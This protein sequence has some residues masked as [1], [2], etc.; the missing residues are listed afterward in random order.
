[1]GDNMKIIKYFW[2]LV[3][4]AVP[5]V[6]AN[7]QNL[8]KLQTGEVGDYLVVRLTSLVDQIVINNV[9]INRG[10]CE[11]PSIGNPKKGTILKFG[12]SKDWRWMVHNSYNG[13][14]YPCEILEIT[15]NTNGGVLTY[16][17]Q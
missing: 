15:I 5:S 8:I 17:P 16:T 7:Q 10:A 2:L 3:F 13:N 6:H 9:T 1:M 12:Q 4:L 14:N 11:N